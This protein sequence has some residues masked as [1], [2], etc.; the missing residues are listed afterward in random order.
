[1]RE[2]NLVEVK[3]VSGG[4]AH[5]SAPG[6][7]D[8]QANDA[9]ESCMAGSSLFDSA[10]TVGG[11]VLGAGAGALICGTTGAGAAMCITGTGA[12]GNEMSNG[13]VEGLCEDFAN[14][15]FE[16]NGINSGDPDDYGFDNGGCHG[17]C[18]W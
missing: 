14:G 8:G 2:L 5:S 15:E 3:N 7:L 4:N 12:I 1:M 10:F 17:N 13:I 9:Y 16:G 6:Q 18:P 11:T